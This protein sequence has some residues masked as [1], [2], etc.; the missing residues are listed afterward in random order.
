MTAPRHL[1]SGDWQRES[2]AAAE[3]LA[4]R[5]RPFEAPAEPPPPEL[6][7]AGPSALARA[8]SALRNL[9]PR[10]VRRAALI[11]AA[12]LVIAGASYGV[13]SALGP[14]ASPWLGVDATSFPVITGAMIV[15]VAPGS[16]ADAAGLKPGEVITGIGNRPVQTPADLN[17]A[18]AG[19]HA[20]QR[21]QI[22]YQLGPGVS[23][24]TTQAT[25]QPQPAGP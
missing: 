10:Q 5:R 24:H 19:L 13:V 14:S 11:A 20:G 25:L 4:E 17:S 2:D 16:P 18:L 6:P 22:E 7:P 21:V 3:E 12:A 15:D 8:Y 9:D 1:W 23:R